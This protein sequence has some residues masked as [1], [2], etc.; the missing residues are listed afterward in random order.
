VVKAFVILSLF[1]VTCLRCDRCRLSDHP[2][3]MESN[4]YNHR[5]EFRERIGF[6]FLHD[7][8]AVFL[9]GALGNS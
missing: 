6:H 2:G 1:C 8:P 4:G 5:D 3:L 7:A 9:D